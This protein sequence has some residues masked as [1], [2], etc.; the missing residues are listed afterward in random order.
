MLP[1][2]HPKDRRPD[3]FEDRFRA[4]SYYS[5]ADA[6]GDAMK[7]MPWSGLALAIAGFAPGIL[8][9]QFAPS[10]VR[11]Q[12]AETAYGLAAGSRIELATKGT[13]R[14]A[15]VTG[16][17]CEPTKTLLWYA[18]CVVPATLEVRDPGSDRPIQELSL[19]S[20]R[21]YKLVPSHQNSRY[22]RDHRDWAPHIVETP[23]LDFDGN[24]DL[25]LSVD[26]PKTF[27]DRRTAAYVWDPK[28]KRYVFDEAINVLAGKA[29][30]VA[31]AESQRLISKERSGPYDPMVDIEY[32]LQDGK[33][34]PVRRTVSQ[35]SATATDVVESE[36][37]DGA[38]VQVATRQEP[39]PPPPPAAP[40]V[41]KTK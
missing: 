26:E 7:R 10:T 27:L 6:Q 36:W 39:P 38:W 14:F 2:K 21:L 13:H 11:A 24:P 16:E 4:I 35:A 28:A 15:L 9:A 5:I 23:D 30:L 12:K 18:V 37:R 41:M 20:V 31:D 22:M 19:E 17:K 3:A 8:Q 25:L 1:W 33:P 40:T 34:I 32:R 29:W